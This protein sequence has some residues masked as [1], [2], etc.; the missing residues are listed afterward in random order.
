MSSGPGCCSAP[1]RMPLPQLQYFCTVVLSSFS[2]RHPVDMLFF[3]TPVQACQPSPDCTSRLQLCEDTVSGAQKVSSRLLG[4]CPSSR[5]VTQFHPYQLCFG[6]TPAHLM[7]QSD[8]HDPPTRF[9]MELYS[10]THL[11]TD[12]KATDSDVDTETDPHLS[13]RPTDHRPKAS[14]VHPGVHR[15]YAYFSPWEQAQQQQVPL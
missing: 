3:K 9:L 7:T 2:T 4:P 15:I 8:E 6:A 14:L 5:P 11:M 12:L 1:R 13:P 10:F